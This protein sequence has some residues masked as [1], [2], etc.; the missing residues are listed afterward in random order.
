[1]IL[2]AA[3]WDHPLILLASVFLASFGLGLGLVVGA[4][5]ARMLRRYMR[6]EGLNGHS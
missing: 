5:V 6:D 3:D 1:M 4:F 2:L